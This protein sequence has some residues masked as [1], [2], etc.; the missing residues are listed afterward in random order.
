ML[1]TIGMLIGLLLD[2][3]FGILLFGC[4]VNASAADIPAFLFLSGAFGGST[5]FIAWCHARRRQLAE[6]IVERQVLQ[7][8]KAKK[9][10]VTPLEIAAD[11]TLAADD[12][13]A[14]LQ[15]LCVKGFGEERVTENGALVYVFDGFLSD[16]QKQDAPRL[17]ED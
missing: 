16:D 2:G 10:R 3:F 4:L 8:I 14:C 7:L 9:G 6:H 12:A 1:Y 11:T 17:L 5:Y 13:K 15:R